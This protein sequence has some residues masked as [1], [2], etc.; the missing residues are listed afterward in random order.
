M[1][2]MLQV[3]RG[4]GCA[5]SGILRCLFPDRE[6]AEHGADVLAVGWLEHAADEGLDVAVGCDDD[7]LAASRGRE[8]FVCQ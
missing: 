4:V 7:G 3:Q 8:F 6:L 2:L 1:T 5:A